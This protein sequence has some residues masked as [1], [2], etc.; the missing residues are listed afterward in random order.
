MPSEYEELEKLAREYGFSVVGRLNMD[1]LIFREEVR[2]MCG[3][4]KCRQYGKSWRC[5]PATG[6]IE[7][8]FALIKDYKSGVIV[9]T[10]GRLEDEFDYETI[11]NTMKEHS[12]GFR[13]LMRE[14]KKLYPDALGMGAG[15]CSR[16]T[17][18]TYPDAPCRFPE[19]SYSSM[20]A[21]GLWV[22]AVCSGSG[23]PYNN[24]KNTVTYISCVLFKEEMK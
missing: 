1:M 2:D 8:S 5:P 13:L 21:Y 16:C 9:E 20:E 7:D 4:D 3:A 18:C 11:E 17:K 10:V 14:I 19:D 24:G 22:S 23:V 6:T 15:T 12:D